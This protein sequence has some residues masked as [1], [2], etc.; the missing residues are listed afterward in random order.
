MKVIT[1]KLPK[2]VASLVRN[3]DFTRCI[4]QGSEVD[5]QI[6]EDGVI[7]S[8]YAI[9]IG[10]NRWEVVDIDDGA[11]MYP[12]VEKGDITSTTEL[13]GLLSSG[14]IF[15]W[16]PLGAIGRPVKKLA[17]KVGKFLSDKWDAKDFTKWLSENVYKGGKVEVL[18]VQEV[19]KGLEGRDYAVEW[20]AG[21]KYVVAKLNV[22]GKEVE[23]VDNWSSKSKEAVEKKWEELTDNGATEDDPYKDLREDDSDIEDSEEAKDDSNSSDVK[24][25][26]KEEEND[27]TSTGDDNNS[28]TD[29]N[30]DEVKDSDTEEDTN[31]S[32]DED[33]V[34]DSD[35]EE[36]EEETEDETGKELDKIDNSSTIGN[37]LEWDTM[38]E[39][40]DD[41]DDDFDDSEI[42]SG[43]IKSAYSE[44]YWEGYK[45]WPSKNNPYKD[46]PE[47]DVWERGRDFREK[48]ALYTI[49]D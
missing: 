7:T 6:K 46:N 32:N 26:E 21:G 42:V 34:E 13:A 44:A 15:S 18:A 4:A 28:S 45:A 47:R 49:S 5:V 37:N 48:V 35:T 43:T 8:I 30:D 12:G 39:V 14:A 20:K 22:F 29:N 33:E 25:N 11:N 23:V 2:A 24:E 17:K 3:N 16:N 41:I 36:E 19:K 9:P 31:T 10:G 1:G 27:D 40:M 38:T